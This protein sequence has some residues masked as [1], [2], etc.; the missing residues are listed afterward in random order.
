MR[1]VVIGLVF[2]VGCT[3]PRDRCFAE[4][5]RDYLGLL[6]AIDVARTNIDRGFA[7]RKEVVSGPDFRFCLGAGDRLVDNVFGGV[8]TCSS[9]RLRTVTRPVPIDVD[10][11]RRKLESMLAL[12]PQARAR[13]DEAALAC[14]SKFPG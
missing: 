8:R 1:F 2:L 4:A 5:D 6:E 3:S 11:E 12:L 10:A 14:N 13:A 7:T 9:P